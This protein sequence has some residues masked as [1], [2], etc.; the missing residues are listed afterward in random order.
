MSEH[1]STVAEIVGQMAGSTKAAAI[2]GP[3]MIA[4]GIASWYGVLQPI[5]AIIASILGIILTCLMI[6]NQ[7]RKWRSGST[8][9]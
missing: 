8:A 5:F 7:W 9:D 4:G 6:A 3:S 2:T 1:H